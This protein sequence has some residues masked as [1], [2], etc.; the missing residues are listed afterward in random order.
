MDFL[1]KEPIDIIVSRRANYINSYFSNISL[2][3]RNNV[4][5]LVCDM[6]KPY[7]KLKENYLH[8]ACVAI[9]SFHVIS[10]LN[11]E[12]IKYFNKIKGKYIELDNLR[13]NELNKGRNRTY[14]SI[15]ASVETRLLQKYTWVFLKKEK[16]IFWDKKFKYNSYFCGKWSIKKVREEFFK[17]DKDLEKMY[18]LKELYYAFNDNIYKNKQEIND[19]LNRLIRL[20]NNSNID[21]FIK[22]SKL[23]KLNCKYIINSFVI[24]NDGKVYRISN[25]PIEGFNRKVKDL[26]RNSRGVSN[27]Q[28]ARARIIWVTRKKCPFKG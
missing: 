1:T 27:F 16:T 21:I 28:V 22:F 4:K 10:H 23:L 26:K 12:F 11:N 9:D 8:S 17:L 20:Y 6:Y 3:E 2:E 24:T 7:I 13:L 19:E 18:E 25:G 14:D 15:Q 5:F